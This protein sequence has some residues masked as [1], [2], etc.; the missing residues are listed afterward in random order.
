LCELVDTL[1]TVRQYSNED[2]QHTHVRGMR[3]LFLMTFYLAK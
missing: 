3:V 1:S 2:T